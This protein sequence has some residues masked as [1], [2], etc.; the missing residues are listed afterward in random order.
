MTPAQQIVAA[1]AADPTTAQWLSGLAPEVQASL[2]EHWQ[3]TIDA[4]LQT[5][6]PVSD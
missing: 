1:L 6:Y 2:L 5:L 4:Q 3:M